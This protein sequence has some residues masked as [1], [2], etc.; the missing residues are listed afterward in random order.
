MDANPNSPIILLLSALISAVYQ[1]IKF[2]PPLL[3]LAGVIILLTGT[4]INAIPHRPTNMPS[5][6]YLMKMSVACLLIGPL[7]EIIVTRPAI[8]IACH[9]LLQSYFL[10]TWCERSR[11]QN[12]RLEEERNQL[13]NHQGKGSSHTPQSIS[14]ANK[15]ANQTPSAPLDGEVKHVTEHTQELDGR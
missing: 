11:V 10:M 2:Y 4:N 9:Q 15:K 7:S 1:A 5:G 6:S 14:P 12:I 3:P 13:K 8:N